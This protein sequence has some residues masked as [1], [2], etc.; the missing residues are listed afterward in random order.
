MASSN[1]RIFSNG[2]D[3][4]LTVFEIDPE[5]GIRTQLSSTIDFDAPTALAY[6]PEDDDVYLTE[7]ISQGRGEVYRLNVGTGVASR[8]WQGRA[9]LTG[10]SIAD[11]G[12]LYVADFESGGS[13]SIIRIDPATGD[14]SFV[15]YSG[16]ATALDFDSQGNLIVAN[17][18]GVVGDICRVDPSTGVATTISS[19][20]Y[21]SAIR[22]IIVVP[23]P[24]PSTAL[25]VG[26][27]LAG[28]AARPRHSKRR[29]PAPMCSLNARARPKY[30]CVSVSRLRPLH[31]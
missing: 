11:D 3:S 18:S 7:V 10:L 9:K 13:Q 21:F 19:G 29:I 31:T 5:S 4:G 12:T 1:G 30:H 15:S 20:G 6:V 2:N 26:I 25:L 16:Y 28:L 27:G 8:V 24:E 22:D 23:V 14:E 17:C